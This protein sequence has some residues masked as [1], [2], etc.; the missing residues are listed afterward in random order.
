VRRLFLRRFLLI[1]ALT[2]V[3]VVAFSLAITIMQEFFSL[4]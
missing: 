3:L 4:P 2:V 1:M